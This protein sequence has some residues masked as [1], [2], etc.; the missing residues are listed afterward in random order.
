MIILHTLNAKYVWRREGRKIKLSPIFKLCTFLTPFP[1]TASFASPH[2]DHI[3]VWGSM[4][5]EIIILN[6]VT[7]TDFSSYAVQNAESQWVSSICG[8]TTAQKANLFKHIE[9]IHFPGAFSYNC[10]LCDQTF[11]NKNSYYKHKNKYHRWNDNNNIL[12]T[13]IIVKPTCL[14]SRWFVLKMDK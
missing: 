3:T 1:T 8:K 2:F 14:K 10:S 5:P 4:C 11:S 9:N 7:G 6:T 13:C 12:T